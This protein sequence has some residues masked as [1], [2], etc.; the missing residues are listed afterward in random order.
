VAAVAAV[1]RL[2]ALMEVLVEVL[3]QQVA[4]VKAIK[5]QRLMLI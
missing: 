4:E 5:Y 3:V 2:Q 1:Q